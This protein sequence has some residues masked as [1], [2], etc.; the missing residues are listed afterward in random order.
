MIVNN[1]YIMDIAIT[2]CKT[3]A[4]LKIDPNDKLPFTI[5]MQAIEDTKKTKGRGLAPPSPRCL[6]RRRSHR[7]PQPRKSRAATMRLAS[8]RSSAKY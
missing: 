1:L 5:P 2:T 6:K 8:S 3:N 7:G 4:P